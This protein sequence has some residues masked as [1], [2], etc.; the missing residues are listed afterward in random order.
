M[1]AN[2]FQ[3]ELLTDK[4]VIFVG[5]VLQVIARLMTVQEVSVVPPNNHE[6]VSD[7]YGE[8][9]LSKGTSTEICKDR[10]KIILVLAEMHDYV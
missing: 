9:A 4:I 3:G 6:L 10:I 1:A 8:I 7:N 5:A 2:I